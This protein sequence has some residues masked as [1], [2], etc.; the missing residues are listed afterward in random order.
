[1]SADTKSAK[2]AN[3]VKSKPGSRIR[4]AIE[5]LRSLSQMPIQ[6]NWHYHL[7]QLPTVEAIQPATW[8]TWAAVPAKPSPEPARTAAPEPSP[9]QISLNVKGQLVWPAGQQVLWLGQ[10]LLIP[11]QLQGYPLAGLLAR[12]GLHWWADQAQIYLN[13]QLL[14]EGDLFDT[15]TRILVRP[16][17]AANTPVQLALRLVSPG[18]D[19]GAL[20]RS[21]LI[22]ETGHPEQREPGFIAD[23][24]M[25]LLTYVEKFQPQSLHNLAQALDEID[26][27]LLG[28]RPAFDQSLKQIRQQLFPLLEK[29]HPSQSWVPFE[30]EFFLDHDDSAEANQTQ[31]NPNHLDPHSNHPSQISSN[32]ETNDLDPSLRRKISLIGHAHLDLAWLWP[33]SETWQVAEQTFKS[34]L[35]LQKDFGDLT[36]CH[37]SPALFAWLETNRPELFAKIQ[38]EV[39]AGRWEIVAGLW[40][41]PDLNLISG[42]SLVR[43]V[44]YG[45]RYVESR[46]GSLCP[47]AWLPDT[48]GFCW[49][50]PQILRQGGVEFFVTQKLRWNDTTTFPHQVFYWQAP[51]GSQIFSMISAPIGESIDPIKMADYAS[52]WE[53]STQT[54]H[55]L[56]LPGVGDHGGGPTRDML[57]LVQRWQTS[58]FLPDLAFSKVEPFLREIEEQLTQPKQPPQPVP[59]WQD[60]LYLE[61]HRG[62]YTTHADQKLANRRSE[63]LLF[64]AEL[65]AAL[66]TLIT[67]ADYPAAP[68][69][70]IW[71]KTL[72][73]Q[74]HDVLPGSSIPAVFADANQDWA[75]IQ[76]I[77][78][79]LLHTAL[80]QL[81][82]AII[83]P[84]PPHPK[85]LPLVIFNALNWQ[86]SGMV[87][88][89][90]P[91][92]PNSHWQVHTVDGQALLTS[93]D[94]HR[95]QFWA[96]E[97]P[98]NGYRLFWL[99]PQQTS[100]LTPPLSTGDFVLEN[101]YLRATLNPV[102]GN[103]SSV[104]DKQQACELLSGAG[105]QLQFF[106]DQGQY[107]DAW[108]IDPDY[109]SQPLPAAKL[110]SIR[111]I[112]T[113]P[114]EQRLEVI[115]RFQSS[116]FCQVYSLSEHAPELK[117]ETTVNWQEHHVLVKAAFPLTVTA[118]SATYDTLCAAI[119]RRTLPNSQPLNLH[120]AAKWEVPALYWADLTGVDQHN[121]VRGV[122]ILNNCKYGY[123]AGPNCLR[124]TLLR[125]SV[126]PDPQADIGEHRFSYAIYSHAGTWQTAETVR[127]GYEFNHP[128]QAVVNYQLPAP[129]AKLPVQGSFFAL[130]NPGDRNLI[131]M[132]FKQAEPEIG[133][134]HSAV[135]PSP[136]WILRC[137]ECHGQPA[138]LHWHSQ[139]LDLVPH[140]AVDILES[141]LPSAQTPETL[142]PMPVDPWRI[143]TLRLRA[144]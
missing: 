125:G 99:V 75:M 101:Q 57:E 52:D 80:Q 55:S 66:S 124:L 47:I 140:Q 38:A 2:S 19:R 109:A 77:G 123:D 115:S 41:E 94:Q 3:S 48:F 132:A 11:D 29:P 17:D 120:Q 23:E 98:A 59:V 4:A 73:N 126:W 37:S 85:S 15:H 112:S 27:S 58:P 136:D 74:F 70:S 78:T 13:G 72:F 131:L 129:Q 110:Q 116:R 90:A 96:P 122:S 83:H 16:A 142:N 133:L 1:M 36:F 49:Q 82:A 104:F 34:V 26:W 46:F 95:L 93:I 35:G 108:N 88:L 9:A 61:F 130:G 68:L 128:L 92:S 114:L 84:E 5:R 28:D 56:W 7:G 138:R 79:E 65:F 102:T 143:T 50:L 141:P 89:A 69:E 91:N 22:L 71:K 31:D 139:L 44:L 97:I 134:E 6:G 81:A 24:L 54:H 119:E 86:R 103:L 60:E 113:N 111:W 100:P 18:H 76:S 107:W 20:V 106:Q 117:I 42:E 12:V 25:V 43:Q 10:E 33:V 51:D 8:K 53:L 127:K 63:T 105:N 137:Y 14:Q 67:G 39:A 62:C 118:I 87:N 64:T 21:Q 144:K 45:Q 40:V 32:S 30:P 135:K 121:H